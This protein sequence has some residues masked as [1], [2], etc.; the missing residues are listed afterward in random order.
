[1]G[2]GLTFLAAVVAD[3][4]GSETTRGFTRPAFGVAALLHAGVTVPGLASFAGDVW[5]VV[6]SFA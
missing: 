3:L 2:I 6:G 5:S 1:M 4:A